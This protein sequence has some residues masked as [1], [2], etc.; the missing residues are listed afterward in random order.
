MPRKKQEP[1]ALETEDIHGLLA[2]AEQGAERALDLLKEKL[3]DSFWL[4][5]VNLGN[6]AEATLIRRMAGGE[7]HLVVREVL[8]RRLAAMKAEIAGPDPSPLEKLLADR[9]A[10]CWLALQQAENAYQSADSL[11]LAQAAF[12][13]KRIDA[14]H[15]RYM[16]AISTLAQ[17]RRL[18]IPP[19]MTQVNIAEQQTNIAAPAAPALAG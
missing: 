14:A 16:T 7:K 10:F 12:A 13:Q 9:I 1:P 4:K 17:V 19:T 2:R 3:D 11:S 5:A 15:R 8:E 18:Q 6:L